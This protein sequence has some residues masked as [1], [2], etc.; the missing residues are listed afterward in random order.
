MG[1]LRPEHHKPVRLADR[2]L[3]AGIDNR[4]PTSI[5]LVARIGTECVPGAIAVALQYW[6]DQLADHATDG[7]RI[8]EVVGMAGMEYDTGRIT[9]DEEVPA[10]VLW[11][12]RLI[13][14][15]AE[16]D[17]AAFR[18]CFDELWSLDSDADR[19]AHVGAV[20]EIAALSIR[21]FPRGYTQIG[22]DTDVLGR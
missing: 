1:D 15:R 10:R 8:A 3:T 16:M 21:I 7:R 14:A 5:R 17:E 22:G 11:A 18:A 4:W 12:R 2:A 19:G 6:C 20:L 13:K 9:P